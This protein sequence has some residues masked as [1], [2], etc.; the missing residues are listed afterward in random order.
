[1]SLLI[2]FSLLL[3]NLLFNI[4]SF[5][6]SFFLGFLG[7]STYVIFLCVILFSI[8]G[9]FGKKP[10]FN[11]SF[12]IYAIVSLFMFVSIIHIITSK[13]ILTDNSYGEYL[14]LAYKNKYTAGGLLNSIFVYPI[15]FITNHF[16]STICIFTI[17]LVTF[18]CLSIYSFYMQHKN[19]VVKYEETDKPM[20]DEKQPKVE[21][22][23][24]KE[25]L[26][27]EIQLEDKPKINEDI[28]VS[29]DDVASNISQS[30]NNTNNDE[31]KKW[32]ED[33][34]KAKSV[35]GLVKDT[36][37]EE[38]A[39]KFESNKDD[40]ANQR[41]RKYVHNEED[42][43]YKYTPSNNFSQNYPKKLTESERKNL[44]FLRATRGEK[45]AEIQTNNMF[46]ATK[47]SQE[48]NDTIQPKSPILNNDENDSLFVSDQFTTP[49][50]KT[51][52]NNKSEIKN[53]FDYT[54]KGNSNYQN[55][56]AY[57]KQ[58]NFPNTLQNTMQSNEITETNPKQPDLYDEN[59]TLNSFNKNK[60]QI[61]NDYINVKSKLQDIGHEIKNAQKVYT[62]ETNSNIVSANSFNKPSINKIESK[63]VR[64]PKQQKIHQ[65]YVKPPTD[66]LRYSPNVERNNDT[67]EQE[68]KARALEE[69]LQS[70]KVP[71]TVDAIVKGPTFTRYEMKM[72]V[73]IP[74]SKIFAYQNDIKM[75]LMT[76]EEIRI[77]A[78]IPGKSA[79]GIE[80]V[81]DKKDI[82]CL[83][84][85]IES[86]T[87]QNSKSP[88][89]FVLGKDIVGDGKVAKLDKAPHLLV[90]GSTGSGK[91]VCLNALLISM[92][93][94][95]SPDDLRLILVDPKKVE[96]SMYNGLPHLLIPNVIT[97]I[98]KAIKAFDW[99]IQE[100]ERRYG[101][102]N[103]L[104]VRAIDSYN[105]HP[106]V[107]S[108]VRPKMPYLVLVVDEVA[109]IM[110]QA[111]KEIED[112]IQ[113]LAAKSR[114]AG[115]HLVLA[116]Q[117]PSTDVITGLIKTNLPTRI[118]F[119]VTSYI[120]SKTILDYGGAEKLI[121]KG[122]MLYMAG[123]SP[124]LVRIQGAFLSD[125]EV[126][127][128]VEFIKD[129]NEPDFDSDIEEEMFSKK[130]NGFDAS[131]GL[132]EEYDPK[133]VDAL[134][135]V[136][137]NNN[138]SISGI[139]RVFGLGYPRAGKIVDQ[140]ERLNF[141][142]PP[143]NKNKRTIF[144]TAQEFEE[145]FGEELW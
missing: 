58:N 122:D 142:S 119:K 34:L 64:E 100:M 128:V 102:L 90:A 26:N 83:R 75:Q 87:F 79:F 124:N 137:R 116:T 2:T 51:T 24:A 78:P 113:R 8:L 20:V 143:D 13:S 55:D 21:N 131:S 16:I 115:I 11:T 6:N 80:V 93:Y 27:K 99:L 32:E 7:L 33:R 92:L 4:F 28:F 37:P 45:L 14:S 96:F 3:I 67:S 61:R 123:D 94:K 139:Q 112:K 111:K 65:P 31:L 141:I 57:N 1:M 73:G 44:E 62:G 53:N 121:G 89:T 56:Y 109:D 77:E 105:A 136:I 133:L 117:R 82:V 120:D 12:I 39:V 103:E 25:S 110:A 66:L 60:E 36:K 42:S 68:V 10:K 98:D 127:D 18:I 140:M 38:N 88:L 84:D 52:F 30:E 130:N 40:Q 41:P 108:G 71:A 81:N 23:I 76:N 118:A 85:I 106:Q 72:P 43:D 48:L 54:N 135:M 132:E 129:N 104:K 5:I 74:V 134:R 70:F 126:E 145:K 19:A 46:K 69:V 29:D 17:L 107:V 35:L 101:L 47:T 63:P 15:Y 50:F 9:L 138:V 91:S 144:I 22:D 114:A 95:N 86:D 97:D 125:K 59:L 49:N